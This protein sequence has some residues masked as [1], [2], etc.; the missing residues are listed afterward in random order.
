MD[1]LVT[2]VLKG[3]YTREVALD[4]F[5]DT[6]GPNGAIRDDAEREFDM[7][8]KAPIVPVFPPEAAVLSILKR[9]PLA[10]STATTAATDS[11]TKIEL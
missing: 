5:M 8:L 2:A 3:R 4:S 1:G 6:F 11:A 10:H 7:T 9:A